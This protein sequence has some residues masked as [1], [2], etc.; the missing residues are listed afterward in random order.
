MRLLICYRK[1]EAMLYDYLIKTYG[2][3]EPI[4][5]A[6]IKCADMSEGNIRQQIK[7]L[8]DAGLI[9]RY[10]T[11]IYFIPKKSIFKSGTQLSMQ[12]VIEKKY[13]KDDDKRCGYI[14][15]VAFANQ[16][17]LTTQ[18]AMECEVVTNKATKEY[19]ETTLAKSRVIIRKPRV[20]VD[21][22]NYRILQFLDLIKDIDYYAEVSKAE[23]QARLTAYMKYYAMSFSDL[24]PYL[25]YYPDKIYKNLYETRLLYG[26]SS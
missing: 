14:T 17:G 13:L 25:Q 2:E 11:G 22:E 9:K 12:R 26:I 19:R 10:D 1:G 15:G 24:E 21:E 3:N 18:V 5:V 6:D 16:L 20:E 4:F 23:Q 8:S 7:R